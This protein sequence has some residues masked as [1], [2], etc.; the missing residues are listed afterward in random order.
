MGRPHLIL[1]HKSGNKGKP[2]AFLYI[3][4]GFFSFSLIIVHSVRSLHG[5]AHMPQVLE[6]RPG[7]T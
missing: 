5:E 4:K 3:Q 7:M 1:A 2:L 6:H